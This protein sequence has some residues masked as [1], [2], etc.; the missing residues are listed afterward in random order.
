M[1]QVTKIGWSGEA[2]PDAAVL[3]HMALHPDDCTYAELMSGGRTRF[4]GKRTALRTR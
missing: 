4:R 3:V 1:E 2:R